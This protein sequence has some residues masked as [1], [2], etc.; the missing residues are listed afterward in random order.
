EPNST[1]RE[2]IG[3]PRFE[4]GCVLWDPK[5]GKHVQYGEIRGVDKSKPPV[6]GLAQWSSR[7]RLEP[8]PARSSPGGGRRRANNAKAVTFGP[9]G[10]DD[11]DVALAVFGSLEYGE[12]AR[13]QGEPWPHL[14][15]E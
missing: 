11:A 6:W 7:E 12:R 4:R 10:S 2:L 15:L 9:L 1:S 5:P 3:D 8:G 13:K 14:L